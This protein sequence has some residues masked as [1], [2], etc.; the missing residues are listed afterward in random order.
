MAYLDEMVVVTNYEFDSDVID[1]LKHV[2][3][4]EVKSLIR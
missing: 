3:M 2:Q 1:G 4:M